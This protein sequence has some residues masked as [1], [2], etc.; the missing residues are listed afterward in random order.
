MAS[1][2]V[3]RR[4]RVGTRVD[5]HAL[6]DIRA[7][8]RRIGR[9]AA[10]SRLPPDRLTQS[11]S[12]V[13][14]TQAP[15]FRSPQKLRPRVVT[16]HTQAAVPAA[17]QAVVRVPQMLSSIVQVPWSGAWRQNFLV[18]LRLRLHPPSSSHC[19]RC[20]ARHCGGSRRACASPVPSRGRS[21]QGHWH[22]P[23]Y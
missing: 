7:A 14:L 13:Q 1:S 19:R 23:G 10:I 2:G 4:G 17:S 6:A 11:A 9:D 5:A 18:V 16:K 22:W 8:G 12:L 15:A 21:S 3:L 20:N